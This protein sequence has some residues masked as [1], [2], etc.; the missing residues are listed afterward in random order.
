MSINTH[1]FNRKPSL[2]E[3]DDK[4]STQTITSGMSINTHKFNRKPSLDETDDKKDFV[5]R[6]CTYFIN[7]KGNKRY[8]S[9]TSKGA[10]LA[11]NFIRILRVI[12]EEPVF[13][14]TNASWIDKISKTT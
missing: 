9:S 11:E 6:F 2:D 4:K 1:K 5:N 7:N 12:F 13:Q 10:I 8:S 3:T 14:K